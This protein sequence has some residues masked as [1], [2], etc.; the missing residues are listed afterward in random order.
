M[1][2]RFHTVAGQ[3]HHVLRDTHT[4][5]LFGSHQALRDMGETEQMVELVSSLGKNL[6]LCD[7]TTGQ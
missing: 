7:V 1:G 6:V 5:Y 4:V 3:Y 2:M